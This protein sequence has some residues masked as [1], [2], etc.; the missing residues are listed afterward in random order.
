MAIPMAPLSSFFLRVD[1]SA[2]VARRS[3]TAIGDLD[4]TVLRTWMSGGRPS[5]QGFLGK[6]MGKPWEKHGKSMGKYMVNG[7]LMDG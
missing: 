5:H 2:F 4:C 3:R 7:W 6:A 1:L